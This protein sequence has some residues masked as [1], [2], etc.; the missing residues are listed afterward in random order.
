[1]EGFTYNNIF[2]TKGIEYLIVIGFFA[3]LIP[4]WILLTRKPVKH[5]YG[6]GISLN[7]NM[8]NVPGG[9]LHSRNHT[10]VHLEKSGNALVGIDDLI[11]HLAGDVKLRTIAEPGEKVKR[12][13]ILAELE[14]KGRL[15]RI[16]SPVSG[17]V[18]ANN[19][20]IIQSPGTLSMD[21]YSEGWIFKIKPAEWQRDTIGYLLGDEAAAFLRSEL[22][23]FRNFLS[24][25]K[26]HLAPDTL[27]VA[28]QDGGELVNNTLEFLPAEIWKEFQVEFMEKNS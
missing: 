26:A 16:L 7:A 28:M 9:V 6:R 3:T 27:Q 12:G 22:D 8:L 19:N 24:G 4:F 25:S 20:S 2:D 1:M 17:T 18:T 23:R 21:P 5:G 11:A 10:W 14:N 13:D 15:L